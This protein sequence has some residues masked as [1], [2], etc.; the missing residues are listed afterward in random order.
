ML[1]LI[2][3]LVNTKITIANY[4][5]TYQKVGF[6]KNIFALPLKHC[7][8]FKIMP[9]NCNY[10]IFKHNRPDPCFFAIIAV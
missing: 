4:Q 2:P 7:H 8:Y 3:L 1:N 10:C 5:F 6:R 9:L